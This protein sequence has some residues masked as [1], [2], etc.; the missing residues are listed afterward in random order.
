MAVFLVVLSQNNFLNFFL[1]WLKIKLTNLSFTNLFCFVSAKNLEKFLQQLFLIFAS[2]L[3]P[4]SLEINL[5]FLFS[6]EYHQL[7]FYFIF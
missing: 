3:R 2:N 6:S 5:N 7:K 4:N 1:L